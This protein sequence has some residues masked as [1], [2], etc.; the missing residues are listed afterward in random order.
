MKRSSVAGR[1]VH[2]PIAAAIAIDPSFGTREVERS[3]V[4]EPFEDRVHAHG[5]SEPVSGFPPKR[6]VVEAEV[7]RFLDYF[8]ERLLGSVDPV[9]RG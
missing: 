8:V 7:S 2:D 3:I 6:I 4:M 5:Q 1:R 9:Y